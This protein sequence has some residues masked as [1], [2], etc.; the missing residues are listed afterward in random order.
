MHRLLWSTRKPPQAA[1]PILLALVLPAC[2]KPQQSPAPK[3]RAERVAQNACENQAAYDQLKAFAFRKA[4]DVRTGDAAV[5]DRLAAAAVARMSDPTAES[6]DEALNATVCKGRMAI[7]LPPGFEDAFNGEH[8][9]AADVKYG[10]QAGADRRI[11]AYPIEGVEPIVYQLAAIDL[12]SGVQVAQSASPKRSASPA[13]PATP[14]SS[15]RRVVGL[16]PRLTNRGRPAFSCY[17]VRSRAE[18]MICADERL[19]AF[20]R[21]MASL[22]DRALDDSDRETRAILRGTQNRFFARRDRCRSAGCMAAAYRDRMDE[23]DRIASEG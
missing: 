15:A 18:Q 12:K 5:L 9:V 1:I 14:A 8:S 6:R 10:V 16:E 7:D 23:I 20:D 21:V 4:K 19:A 22:Y 13:A 11:R 3:S 2:D 17:R